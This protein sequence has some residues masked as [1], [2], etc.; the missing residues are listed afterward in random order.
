MEYNNLAE[1]E[2]CINK[3]IDSLFPTSEWNNY[4][5]EV[6][7]KVIALD[8]DH[9]AQYQYIMKEFHKMN[10][11]RKWDKALV[12]N[13]YKSQM[14][15]I[16][17]HEKADA[18]DS[19]AMCTQLF[20]GWDVPTKLINASFY[21]ACDYKEGEATDGLECHINKRWTIEEV[22]EML[23]EADINVT[24][25]MVQMMFDEIIKAQTEHEIDNDSLTE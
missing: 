12:V 11:E 17:K 2:N 22:R 9:E 6:N 8:N 5:T 20:I 24:D 14:H 16:G 4:I 15:I 13:W 18:F 10:A 25:E 1:R 19:M 21:D 7:K 23:K 3:T